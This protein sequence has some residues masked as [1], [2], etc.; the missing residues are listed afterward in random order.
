[1]NIDNIALVRA[2]NVIPFDGIVR[3]ISNDYY[4]CKNIS[5]YFPAAISDLLKELGI[6]P[7]YDPSKA[8]EEDSY[9]KHIHKCSEILKEYLPYISDYNSVVLFALNGICPDDN[10]HGFANNTFSNRKCAV[11]DSLSSHVDK[12][13]SLV[14]TDTAIKG[15][16]ELSPDAI[17][18]IEE[19]T[20]LLLS[21][22]QKYMLSTLNLTV[23][24]FKGTLK[25]A[26]QT[27]LKQSGRY[28]CEEL[29]LTRS[30]GGFK[31]SETSEM[32]K[33]CIN[34]IAIEYGLSQLKYLNLIT[35]RNGEEIPKYDEISNEY[36]NALKVQEYYL[37]Q[38]LEELLVE[39][40]APEYF[41]NE[42]DDN[43]YS[44][45]FMK[46]VA[47]LIKEYG[48]D[49]YKFFVE[50]YNLKLKE[51]QKNRTLLTPEEIVNGKEKTK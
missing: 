42:L 48:I 8:F 21:D 16:V 27:E 17:I 40:N 20:Y 45:Y 19:E 28:I 22:E 36:S 44:K 50:Q 15:N 26:I 30:T 14:P 46:D 32:Q 9:D 34:A 38:F 24:T 37:K 31:P 11:I 47:V 39:I 5:G 2:T 3:P 29:S 49:K 1:M 18:L 13:V 7:K 4:I 12:V 6:I 43:L 33:E 51:Q 23:K 25:E 10:E 41:I 35:A